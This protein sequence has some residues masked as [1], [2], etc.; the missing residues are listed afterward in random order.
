M[1]KSEDK[2]LDVMLYF[3]PKVY[4]YDSYAVNSTRPLLNSLKVHILHLK[5]GNGCV[6]M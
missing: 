2:F 4:F 5:S 1:L 6:M 3:D